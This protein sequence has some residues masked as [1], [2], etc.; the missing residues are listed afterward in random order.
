[1]FKIF[2]APALKSLNLKSN[3]FD[4]DWE[5]SGKLA[6]R[7]SKFAEVPVSYRARSRAEGKKIRFWR[8]GWMVFKAIVRY[9]FID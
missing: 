9:R 8:D 2:R 5:I 3:G 6:L 4:Y 1:M 7:G